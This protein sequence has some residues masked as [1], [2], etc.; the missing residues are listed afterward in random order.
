[1]T[2]VV[3]NGLLLAFNIGAVLFQT[4][5]GRVVVGTRARYVLTSIAWTCVPG[6][7]AYPV[8]GA[9]QKSVTGDGAPTWMIAINF[10]VIVW[11]IYDLIKADDDNWYRRRRKKLGQWIR[12]HLTRQPDAAGARA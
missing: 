3:L 1:M 10:A 8:I 7:A 6:G 5:A 2:W 12:G 11:V 4:A 9:I